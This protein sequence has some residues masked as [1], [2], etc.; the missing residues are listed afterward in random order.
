MIPPL[1][2][3][4]DG[5]VFCTDNTSTWELPLLPLT[6]SLAKLNWSAVLQMSA[7]PPATVQVP[8]VTVA[9][10]A[11]RGEPMSRSVQP[12][13]RAAEARL[14]AMQTADKSKSRRPKEK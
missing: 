8:L 6:F 9:E 14:P 5:S 11:C 2:Q 1:D 7:P 12:E 4:L 10:P 13:G 3:P